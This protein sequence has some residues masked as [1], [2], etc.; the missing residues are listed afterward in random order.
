MDKIK[1]NKT[2]LKFQDKATKGK[3]K[4]STNINQER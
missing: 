2:K 3:I 4:L 1:K